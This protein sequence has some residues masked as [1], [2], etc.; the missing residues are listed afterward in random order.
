MLRFSKG[1]LGDF[2]KNLQSKRFVSCFL[3]Q[4]LQQDFEVAVHSDSNR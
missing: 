2:K 3:F 1:M 4:R